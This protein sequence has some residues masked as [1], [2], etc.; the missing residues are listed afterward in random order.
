MDFKSHVV[1]ILGKHCKFE[2]CTKFMV[3]CKLFFSRNI[4]RFGNLTAELNPHSD[5]LPS[6]PQHF[7]M[8]KRPTT[9][10]VRAPLTP[11]T[12]S[13]R[14]RDP[15][16]L[17]PIGSLG[18]VFLHPRPLSSGH[19]G[20]SHHQIH[21]A[22]VL[23]AAQNLV[24][25][26]VA[27]LMSPRMLSTTAWGLCTLVWTCSIPILISLM[28]SNAVFVHLDIKGSVLSPACWLHT[29]PPRPNLAICIW[30]GCAEIGFWD[31][32]TWE[33]PCRPHAR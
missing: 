9:L 18:L 7:A 1:W 17:N 4:F 25:A 32:I 13:A 5:T 23:Q 16:S 22:L 10:V 12:H 24:G 31:H 28:S 14:C 33:C 15:D 6:Y 27:K 19:I 21:P 29:H 30:E 8:W 3:G 11:V 20:K 26:L 2:V